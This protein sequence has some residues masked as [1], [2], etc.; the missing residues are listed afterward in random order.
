MRP[1]VKDITR[2][3][4][5]NISDNMHILNQCLRY[6]RWKWVNSLHIKVPPMI[7]HRVLII[8]K[9]IINLLKRGIKYQATL[10]VFHVLPH[11]V[12][13]II[14]RLQMIDLGITHFLQQT[15]YFS[16]DVNSTEFNLP[17]HHT[18]VMLLLM[19]S[20]LVEIS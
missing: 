2:V 6:A 5:I 20:I 18:S 17:M 8:K 3:I 4:H 19:D 7:N 1:P 13:Y 10:I 15:T 12:V 14:N 11:V 9:S 16:H